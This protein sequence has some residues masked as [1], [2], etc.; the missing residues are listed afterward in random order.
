M[1]RSWRI[2]DAVLTSV[3][4]Y[5]GPVHIPSVL[6]PDMDHSVLSRHR[7]ILEGSHWVES[8]DRLVIGVQIWVL[9][10]E[11]RVILIDTGIGNHK[12][13]RTPRANQLNTVVAD[14]LAAAGATADS[15]TDVVITHLHS[16]HIGGN[17]VLD[18]GAWVPAYPR[19]TY[20]LPR[21]DYEWFAARDAAGHSTDGGSFADSV[22][23]V[24][25]RAE[26]AFVDP[27]DQ[28]AGVL[29]AVAAAGHTPGHTA[30]RF[31]SGGHEVMFCGDILHH[32]VQIYRPDWNSIVDI[33]PEIAEVTRA[34]FLAEA[35]AE[36]F[37]IAPCHFGPPHCGFVRKSDPYAFEP[38]DAGHVV[39]Q[40]STSPWTGRPD[41][42][43]DATDQPSKPEMNLTG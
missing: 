31:S 6:Y 27:G 42:G 22:A 43:P 41:R 28:V 14:W 36:G 35:A 25:A 21:A 16:D 19:A 29:T 10:T 13:R 23:P 11:G 24:M 8:I 12:P 2:G 30:Y 39:S 18:G 32:P 9:R 15:V 1:I 3:V 33:Q 26:V 5:F 40:L 37:L 38:A 20:H 4:E 7:A 34:A 17:T